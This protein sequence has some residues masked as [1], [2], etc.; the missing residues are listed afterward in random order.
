MSREL[1]KDVEGSVRRLSRYNNPVFAWR[2]WGKL[3]ETSEYMVSVLRFELGPLEYE[4][5]FNH[6]FRNNLLF[7]ITFIRIYILY[8]EYLDTYGE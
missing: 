6:V 3:R 2:R 4:P 7:F 1:K 8:N 5:S